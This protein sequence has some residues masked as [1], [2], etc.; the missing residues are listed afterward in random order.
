MFKTA[1][2]EFFLFSEAEIKATFNGIIIPL[3]LTLFSKNLLIGLCWILL[4]T[5]IYKF[6]HKNKTEN[7]KYFFKLLKLLTFIFILFINIIL[8]GK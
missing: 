1:K 3:I 8:I 4:V 7:A 5:I 6:I 2:K